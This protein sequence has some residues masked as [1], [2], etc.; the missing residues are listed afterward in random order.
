MKTALFIAISMFLESRK[1][2]CRIECGKTT[3]VASPKAEED[4][5]SSEHSSAEGRGHVSEMSLS[6]E[7][8]VAFFLFRHEKPILSSASMTEDS[9]ET[10]C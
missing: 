6:L 5:S 7:P 2:R 8:W 1:R 3:G 4:K 9:P 10:T